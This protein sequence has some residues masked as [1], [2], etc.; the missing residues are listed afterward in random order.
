MAGA[1]VATATAEALVRLITADASAR[2]GRGDGTG[3]NAVEKKATAII[4]C[5]PFYRGGGYRAPHLL[6]AIRISLKRAVKVRGRG[7]S[8]V[9]DLCVAV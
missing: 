9:C 1:T 2:N 6:R 7:R 8:G 5:M 3:Y 4:R